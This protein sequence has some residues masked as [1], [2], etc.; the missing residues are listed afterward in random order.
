MRVTVEFEDE[1]R[2]RGM[3]TIAPS[4]FGRFFGRSRVASIRF[5]QILGWRYQV[6]GEWIGSDL[7]TLVN[8]HR[9]W[10]ERVQVPAAHVVRRRTP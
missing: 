1:A 5:D 9:R 7:E 8:E 4:W 2:T 3:L 10:Q 6:D